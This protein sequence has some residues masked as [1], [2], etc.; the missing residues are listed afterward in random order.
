MD[1]NTDTK[2]LNRIA[3]EHGIVLEHYKNFVA[4]LFKTKNDEPSWNM[5]HA[6]L[7]IAGESGEVVDL[8]KKT[9]A[10]GK[11]LDLN[12]LKHEMGDLFF[13]F[14]AL[15]NVTGINLIEIIAA[16]TEKLSARYPNGYSDVAAQQRAD[17]A[18]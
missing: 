3:L 15:C 17:E 18:K 13:Y 7:G 14:T 9:F 5:G 1:I 2:E 16:N 6:A 4:G 12:K 11:P 8:I 10:N